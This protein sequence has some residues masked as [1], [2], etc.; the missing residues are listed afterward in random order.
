M[1]QGHRSVPELLE[2]LKGQSLWNC[3][4]QNQN[5]DEINAVMVNLVETLFPGMKKPE[6]DKAGIHWGNVNELRN[7]LKANSTGLAE[8]LYSMIREDDGYTW[9]R[10]EV[11]SNAR[12]DSNIA[13]CNVIV[14]ACQAH[15]DHIF[16]S[17]RP[18]E[19]LMKLAECSGEDKTEE[20]FKLFCSDE[21]RLKGLTESECLPVAQYPQL[22]L[23][24]LQQISPESP[25]RKTLE[26]K[27]AYALKEIKEDAWQKEFEGK[28]ILLP[29]VVYL[30]G[31]GIAPFL[32]NS[33]LA[34]FQ[35]MIVSTIKEQYRWNITTEQLR[36]CYLALGQSFR[37][38]ID[39]G[40]ADALLTNSFAIHTAAVKEFVLGTPNFAEWL[41]PRLSELQAKA[42]SLANPNNIQAFSNFLIFIERNKDN[43][44]NIC[45]IGEVIAKPVRD[46]ISSNNHAIRTIGE[47]A[48]SLFGLISPDSEEKQA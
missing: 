4:R 15:D 41:R 40:I 24:F 29:L 36:C 45:G 11:L 19:T 25:L 43:I 22:T 10:E 47:K 32:D 23:R 21:T 8:L 5:V 2:L 1:A 27:C 26:A 14:L 28:P 3:W 16:N 38:T 42:P 18:Y 46:M 31:Q 33:F 35:K 9:L 7:I 12:Q 44:T 48:A 34:A 20:L 30:V 13:I 17:S 39:Y 37:N 6:V